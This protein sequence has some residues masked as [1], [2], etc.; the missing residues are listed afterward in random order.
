MKEIKII[1]YILFIMRVIGR[2]NTSSGF[3]IL[4]RNGGIHRLTDAHTTIGHGVSKEY[5][6]DTNVS[7][8]FKSLVAKKDG[9]KAL[10]SIKLKSSNPK[11]YISF[12]L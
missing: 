3:G 5:I 11:K 2:Q 4:R 7:H 8:P 12:N 6:K 9:V 1:F 10:E